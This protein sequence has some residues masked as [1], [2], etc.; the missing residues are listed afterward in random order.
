ML[1]NN[2]KQLLLAIHDAHDVPGLDIATITRL[3]GAAIDKALVDVVSAIS[4]R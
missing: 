4:S 2:V 1:R 3:H